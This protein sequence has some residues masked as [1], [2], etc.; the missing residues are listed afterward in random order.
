MRCGNRLNDIV[1]VISELQA[2]QCSAWGPNAA[3]YTPYDWAADSNGSLAAAATAATALCPC[4]LIFDTSTQQLSGAV[5]ATGTLATTSSGTQ[6]AV[7]SFEQ[8]RIGPEVHITVRGQLPLVLLSRSALV[9]NTTISAAPAT[10]GGFR[11]GGG[12]A[13]ALL[14]DPLSDTHLEMSLADL[15][16]A[17]SAGAQLGAP[18]NSLNGP[19]SSSLRY[20]AFT[21]AVSAVPTVE[22]QRL[23]VSARAG[24]TLGGCFTLALP[25]TNTSTNSTS[26]SSSSSSEALLAGRVTQCMPFSFSAAALQRELEVAF[27]DQ[28]PLDPRPL[29]Y[30]RDTTTSSNSSTKS[31]SASSTI[32]LGVGTVQ[33]QSVGLPDDQGGRCWELSFPS[34]IG[35]DLPLLTVDPSALTGGGASAAV[36]PL[37]NSSALGGHWQLR[38]LGQGDAHSTPLLPHNASA[39]TLAA[40]LQ[41]LPGVASATVQRTDA[42]AECRDGL[43]SDGASPQ[44]SGGGFVWTV[45]LATAVGNVV[46]T[47][48]A[49]ALTSASEGPAQW[50]YAVSYL[51]GNSAAVTL[52]QGWSDSPSSGHSRFT[53]VQPFAI[54]CAGAGG[55]YGGAGG[56]IRGPASVQYGDDRLLDLLG[57]SG[58]GCAGLHPHEIYYMNQVQRLHTC[59]HHIA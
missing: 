32:A 59:T 54:A 55:S 31:T 5:T 20:Y 38:F 33:V 2:S 51:T 35:G 50:P 46:P 45:E 21:V 13:R 39:S 48:P 41:A 40:A 58:G 57:G 3:C 11:G 30:N 9:L 19:G 15:V 28:D 1:A 36:K 56:S 53:V 42:A 26:S 52:H 12:I 18:S 25:A 43:C 49:D 47:W 23:C 16:A 10:L 44:S 14:D 27:N 37:S 4:E 7:W 34:Y 22:A 17:N 29:P 24:Q 8:V 6:V